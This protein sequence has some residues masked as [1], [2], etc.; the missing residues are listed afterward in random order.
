MLVVE[1][2]ANQRRRMCMHASARARACGVSVW[3]VYVVYVMCSV[4]LRCV[5][6]VDE[7]V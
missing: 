7:I 2:H 1:V 6:A 3:C 5:R 4:R